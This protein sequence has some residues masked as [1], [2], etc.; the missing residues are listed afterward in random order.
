[1]QF[2]AFSNTLKLS[3]KKCNIFFDFRSTSRSEWDWLQPVKHMLRQPKE[4]PATRFH[5]FFLF[6]LFLSLFFQFLLVVLYISV[7]SFYI[8]SFFDKARFYCLFLSASIV[9]FCLKS[10][11]FSSLLKVK[12]WV[13]IIIFSL[14]LHLCFFKVLFSFVAFSVGLYLCLSFVSK[15]K[16][17]WF[18]L[19]NYYDYHV[20]DY[21]E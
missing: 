2:S 17:F 21:I 5:F 9:I 19:V 10:L 16:L 15:K 11:S 8:S 6:C 20:Q 1:M 3:Q 14:Y 13:S 18:F 4:K 7:S 12:I